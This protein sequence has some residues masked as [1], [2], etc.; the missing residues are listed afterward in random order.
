MLYKQAIAQDLRFKNKF[1]DLISKKNAQ[2][3]TCNFRGWIDLLGG[4]R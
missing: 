4:R 2:N 3:L 1:E